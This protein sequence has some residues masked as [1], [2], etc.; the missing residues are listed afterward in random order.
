MI[1]SGKPKHLRLN[2][3][4]IMRCR[5][6]IFTLDSLGT[7]HPQAQKVLR[8]WLKAEAKDKRELDNVRLAEAKFAQVCGVPFCNKRLSQKRSTTGSITT[9][10]CRLRR[11][12]ATF[13]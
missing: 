7:R 10:L 13:R 4:F 8:Y 12:P 5:T 3:R 9:Q 2:D 6:W 1:L 11:L